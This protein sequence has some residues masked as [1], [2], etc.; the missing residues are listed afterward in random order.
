MSEYHKS[1]LHRQIISEV[2]K[3]KVISKEQ[4]KKQSEAMK[5]LYASGYKHPRLGI[6]H[7]EEAKEK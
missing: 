6:T 4:K 1:L 3:G 7:T 5:E 2:H